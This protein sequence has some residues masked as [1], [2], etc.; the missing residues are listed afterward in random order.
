MN[1]VGPNGSVATAVALSVALGHHISSRKEIA[2]I[3]QVTP[4]TRKNHAKRIKLV[5]HN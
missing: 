5:N 4:T 1:G 3:G 2:R